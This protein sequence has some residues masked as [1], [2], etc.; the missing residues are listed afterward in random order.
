L[1]F[2]FFLFFYFCFHSNSYIYILFLINNDDLNLLIFHSRQNDQ[3][4][5]ELFPPALQIH[6]SNSFSCSSEW[7]N[8]FS[9]YQ[10]SL[11]YPIRNVYCQHNGRSAGCAHCLYVFPFRE[12]TRS[13]FSS[14]GIEGS[15]SLI[16]S[17]MRVCSSSA[18][19]FLFS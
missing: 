16:R 19:A 12:M 11:P 10:M 14:H 5:D 8:S 1:F 13:L 4:Q 2:L 15:S 17:L 9:P 6:S 3:I 18:F 7:T